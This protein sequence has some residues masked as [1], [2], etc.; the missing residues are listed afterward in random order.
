MIVFLACVQNEAISY[1]EF[2]IS[3]E[4]VLQIA[5]QIASGMAYLTTKKFV[6]R[7]LA[8]RNCMVTG[9]VSIKIG[10]IFSM[11]I[12]YLFTYLSN[13]NWSRFWI[14]SGRVSL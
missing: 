5:V 6:H 4:E 3:E 13:Q 14:D 9:D 8:A 12:T 10:G 7:D 1:E 2:P 11:H